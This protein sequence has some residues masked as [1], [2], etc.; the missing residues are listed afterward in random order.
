MVTASLRTDSAETGQRSRAK[1]LLEA[2]PFPTLLICLVGALLL[3]ALAPALIVGDTWLTL[4]AG[5][6]VA[7]HGLPDT[8]SITTL[9]RGAT[10]T[11]QQWLAQLVFYGV[12]VAGGIRAVVLL[13]IALVLLALTLCV[14]TARANGATGRS[15]FVVLLL[16]V[17]AGPWG[18]TVRAQSLALPLFA[19][20]LGLLIDAARRG[21]RGRTML[22][23][24]IL[25]VWGN[26]HGSV[27]LGALLAMILA[28]Y[29]LATGRRHGWKLPLLLLIGAPL[30]VLA[31]PYA[32]RL[33]A[34]YHLMLVD[35]PFADL[36]REWGWSAPG[37][38]TFLFYV[39]AALTVVLVV[40]RR[41]GGRLTIFEIVVLA[42][43]L[44]GAIQAIRGVIWFALA[45][46]AILPTALDGVI[47]RDDPVAPRINRAISISCFAGLA[48]ATL[49]AV[50]VLPT[51]RFLSNWP[52]REVKAVAGAVS[53]PSARLFA[54]DHDADWLLWRI[55]SLRGRMAY[56]VRFE[57][58]DRPTLE[59]IIQFDRGRG[60]DWRSIATGYDIV[61]LDLTKNGPRRLRALLAEPRAT[62]VYS[63]DRIAIVDR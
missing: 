4:A 12:D 55:P 39:L 20:T 25:V 7:Q 41:S 14:A 46:A 21:V 23:L 10:W 13:D 56:D 32:T 17:V 50:F 45:A 24:P 29:E 52:E 26:F 35:A 3:L 58:Y 22:V 31:S 61:V 1:R 49:I 40:I 43:T 5:R 51:S 11:D 8:E 37:A 30:S 19:A 2:N 60:G 38:E 33:P 48:V 15:T 16:A 47:G 53:D 18:W 62:L 27:V 36:L 42:V 59:R 6:E 28:V 63:D 57:L 54:T 44:V 34:Y 9:G